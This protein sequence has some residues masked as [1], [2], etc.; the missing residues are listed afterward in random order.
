MTTKSNSHSGKSG[1]DAEDNDSY[2]DNDVDNNTPDA[3][4]NTSDDDS[5]DDSD[6]ADDNNT[7]NRTTMTTLDASARFCRTEVRFFSQI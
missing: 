1:A 4:N 6:D 3:D 2:D 5:E 7:K